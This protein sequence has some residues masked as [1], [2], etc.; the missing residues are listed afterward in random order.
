MKDIIKSPDAALYLG[1]ASIINVNIYLT[2]AALI[3]CICSLYSLYSERK[4]GTI[5]AWAG[6]LLAL[7]PY[8]GLLYVMLFVALTIYK[9]LIR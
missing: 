4:K 3:V 5:K 7:F 9:K 2:S 6:L 8:L 1:I